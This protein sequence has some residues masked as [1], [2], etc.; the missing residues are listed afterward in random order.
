MGKPT[1]FLEIE[2]HDRGY[3]KADGAR[4]ELARIRQAA[5]GGRAQQAGGA[6]HGLRHPVL[7]PGLPGQQSDPRL[8]QPGL[9]RAVAGGARRR[10]T[11]P[12]ISRNSP[13]A[14]ARRR[15]RR[16]APSTSTTIRSPSKPSNARSSIAAGKKAGSSRWCRAHRT[17]KRVA[18]V[19]SGP[20]GLA[21]AQQLARAGH[22]V[23]LFEKA[24]RIGGLLRYGI[25][26]FKMEKHLIDRRMAQME[27]EGVEFRAGVEVGVDVTVD[28]L[29]HDYDAVV[30]VRRRGMAARSRNS[31]PR[32]RRHPFRDG[33]PDPAEQAR[34]RR[35]GRVAA[36]E[37]HDLAPRAST[38]SSSAAATPARTA[39]APP[40]AR[41]RPRSPSSKSCRMPPEHENK[42]LTWPDWPLKLRTSSSQEE[43]GERDWSVVTN[44]AVGDERQD[45]GAR[46]RARRMGRATPTA[47]C[48]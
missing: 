38:S 2:R 21:C 34:R 19:G 7:S 43:G 32:A 1:G 30:H 23:T 33:F 12:T 14:S 17:G 27:A 22:A 24:D 31:R 6:L 20:A 5:A 36:P 48:R 37:R 3:E 42:A 15:A 47:A 35:R 44:R 18:V 16:P 10:C 26:D 45:R 39:S 9:S 40:T 4:P 28:E 25:P 46:M 41:A 13:A 29:L 11:R 8:E